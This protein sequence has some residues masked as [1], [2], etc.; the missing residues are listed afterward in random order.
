MLIISVR[1]NEDNRWKS[2]EKKQQQTNKYRK[3]KEGTEAV[4]VKW[5]ELNDFVVHLN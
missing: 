1:D 4:K 3:E 2:K 5:W